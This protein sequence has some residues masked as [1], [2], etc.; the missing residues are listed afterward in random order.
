[1]Y[2]LLIYNYIKTP[3]DI[4]YEIL[5]MEKKYLFGMI[6]R[7]VIKLTLAGKIPHIMNFI[8]NQNCLFNYLFIS[9]CIFPDNVTC[10]A[11]AVLVPTLFTRLASN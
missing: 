6:L 8:Y 9:F 4:V 11:L 3:V 7:I 5:K 10:I 1:M 2:L